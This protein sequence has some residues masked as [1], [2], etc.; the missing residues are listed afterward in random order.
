MTCTSLPRSRGRDPGSGFDGLAVNLTP[1]GSIGLVY[2]H[3]G[4]QGDGAIESSRA[5]PGRIL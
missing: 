3:A 2:L 4:A 5:S 1:E